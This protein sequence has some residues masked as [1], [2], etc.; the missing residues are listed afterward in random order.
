MTNICKP[1]L[2]TANRIIGKAFFCLPHFASNAAIVGSTKIVWVLV[3]L[4]THI[5]GA[6]LYFFLARGNRGSRPLV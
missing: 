4:F 5:L 3:I 1:I 2:Q 6:L